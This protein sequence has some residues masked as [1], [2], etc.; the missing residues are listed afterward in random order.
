MVWNEYCVL[1]FM[2]LATKS[3]PRQSSCTFAAN[4]AFY[5][6]TTYSSRVWLLPVVLTP[7]DAVMALSRDSRELSLVLGVSYGVAVADPAG[8]EWWR[9]NRAARPRDECMQRPF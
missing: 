4:Y 7:G 2:P 3:P 5:L 1:L 6:R 9:H 8:A